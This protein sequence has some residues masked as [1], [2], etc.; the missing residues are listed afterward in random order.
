VMGRWSAKLA[1]LFVEL[2]GVQKGGRVIDVGCGT[3]S[4]VQAI[5]TWDS[6]AR[7]T[8]IDP[9]QALVGEPGGKDHPVADGVGAPSVLVDPGAGVEVGRSDVGDDTGGV[10]ADDH[11]ASTLGGTALHPVE[12]V[13]VGLQHVGEADPAASGRLGTDR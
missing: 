12:I 10:A 3:G 9:V 2:A 5:S 1:P 11:R 6:T 13:A 8:G 7:I 4:M